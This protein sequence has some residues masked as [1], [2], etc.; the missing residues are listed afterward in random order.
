MKNI[1]RFIYETR[2]IAL[3]ENTVSGENFRFTVLTPS[4]I[5]MEYSANGIFEDRAS[6]TVFFRDFPQVFFNKT[7]SDGILKIETENLL[8]SYKENSPFRADTLSIKLKTEPASSWNFGEAF[9]DLGGTA[10]TLDEANGAIKLGRGVCSRNGFSV[11]DD[12]NSMLLN[13]NGWVEVRTPE[14][15]DLYFFGYGFDYLGAVKDFYRLTGAPPM[16]PDYA[17]G[18]WWSRYHKYTQDEYEE[19]IKR[20]EEEDVPFSVSRMVSTSAAV[21]ASSKVVSSALVMIIWEAL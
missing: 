3:S 12:S 1:K 8:L 15:S 11:I 19:L 21:L 14:T 9:E 18:N 4:L 7:I 10:R 13:E 16:L 20:F 5:R 6:Q 2:P 17:L